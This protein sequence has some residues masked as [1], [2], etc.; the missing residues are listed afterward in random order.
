[1]EVIQGVLIPLLDI[2]LILICALGTFAGIFIG[3]I[4][5][6]SVTMAVALLLSLT[7]SWDLYPALALMIGVF[8]G[9]VYG[10]S[11]AA[12]LVNMPGGPASVATSFDG[13]PMA[14]NGEA[15]M[16]LSLTTIASFIGGLIGIIFLAFAAPYIGK[17]TI[18]FAP[19]DYFIVALVGL[20]LVGGLSKGSLGKGIFAA[21]LGVLIGLIGMDPLNGTQRF[22]FGQ[23]SLMTGVNFIT[24]VVGLFG[25]SEVLYQL[26][27]LHEKDQ[28]IT[29]EKIVIPPLKFLLKFLPLSIRTSVIGSIVGVL[30]GV[31]AD[32]AALLAY[33]HAKTTV[34]KPSKPFG[35]GSYE[36]VIAPEAANNAA[37]GGAFIPMLTLGIPG[38]AVTAI[39]IGALFIHGLQPGPLLMANSP[40]LF[41]TMVGI[42]FLAN[43][44][45]LIFG[46]LVVKVFLKVVQVPKP[47]LLPIIMLISII[48][49][50]AVNNSMADVYW[51]LFFGLVGF[52]MKVNDFSVGPIVLGIIL[53][54]LV[55]VNFRRAYMDSGNEMFSF[56]T[57][58]FTSPI[59][60][61]LVIFFI[62][63]IFIQTP[64]Y[65]K[66]KLITKKKKDKEIST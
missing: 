39:F 37:L 58:F 29:M 6:L 35:K 19:R 47:I 13:Y 21:G 26:K 55:D 41:G 18:Q 24:A 17:L 52:F 40:D 36:G 57:S 51:M 34:K 65:E 3:A 49:A 50:Y 25:V 16:A 5:G 20:L 4:P 33:D 63:A 8:F 15:G 27:K 44:F 64:W 32:I 59:S 66:M 54:P 22:T 60:I 42:A 28:T 46:L 43:L 61:C 53:G 48:G 7:Y 9:G 11:R 62:F 1:M 56:F 38:D 31:G 12:I 10:G 2:K 30:P 45:M 14:K 23:L